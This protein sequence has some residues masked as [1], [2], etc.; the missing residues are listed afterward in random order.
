MI[1]KLWPFSVT[2]GLLLFLVALEI[3]IFGFVPGASDPE[4]KLYIC[5][6]LLLASLGMFFL[7]FV[8]GFAYDIGV[9]KLGEVIQ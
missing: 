4:Q 2:I 1:A 5:W 3:A 8:S 6:S 7:S 9:R